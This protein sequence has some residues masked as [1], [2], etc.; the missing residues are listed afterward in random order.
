MP[1]DLDIRTKILILWVNGLF[2]SYSRYK[3][4]IHLRMYKNLQQGL[5]ANWDK[6]KNV[7]DLHKTP[8]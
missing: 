6:S 7:Q 4:V 3:C 5:C 1:F 2:M 8:I